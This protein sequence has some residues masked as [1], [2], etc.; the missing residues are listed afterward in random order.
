MQK[1]I[2][3]YKEGLDKSLN[4]VNQLLEK[5]G[6]DDSG[7][8][9]YCD[10]ILSLSCENIAKKWLAGRKYLR[11]LFVREAFASFYPEKNI[12]ISIY[13]DT[14]VNILDDL[15]DEEINSEEKKL[16]ILELLRVFS[17]YNYEHPSKEVQTYLGNYLNKLISLAIVEDHY[18]NLIDGEDEIKKIVSYSIKVLDC[19][20]MDID[21]FNEMAIL[22]NYNNYNS[23]EEEKIK[24]IGRMFRAVNI[25]KK[26]IEDL[27]YDKETGQESMV[28]KIKDRGKIDFYKYVLAVSDYYLNEADKIRTMK[29]ADAAYEVPVNNFYNMIG[30]DKN[31]IIELVK[32][33]CCL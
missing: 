23:I 5:K 17:L 29:L 32:R 28:S 2:K 9:N 19:R 14:I 26:D 25:M 13:T 4:E 15:L 22:Y 7:I 24:K 12:K 6:M 11:T 30:R 31:K 18:K 3:T 20:S 27:D 21:I 33:R 8:K 10:E 1:I 16:Y